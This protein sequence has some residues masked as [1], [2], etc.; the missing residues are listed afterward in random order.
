MTGQSLSLEELPVVWR[1]AILPRQYRPRGPLV[2]VHLVPAAPGTHHATPDLER[3]R[4]ELAE[5]GFVGEQPVHAGSSE[6]GAWAF[7]TAGESGL[8]VLS[9]GQRTCWFPLPEE[10]FDREALALRVAA[11]LTALLAIGLPLPDALAPAI[12]L[13]PVAATT[14]VATRSVRSPGRIRMGTVAAFPADELRRTAR[15]IAEDLV[16]RLAAPLS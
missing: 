2:E 7:S 9:S 3:T 6:D 1:S 8:A 14:T 12:G 4:G 15:E 5:S 11:R 10:S 13:D 16:A